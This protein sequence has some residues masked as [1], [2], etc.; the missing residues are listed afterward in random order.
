MIELY[1]EEVVNELENTRDIM[2]AYVDWEEET[3][4]WRKRRKMLERLFKA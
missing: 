3:L 4:K 1:G 2:K